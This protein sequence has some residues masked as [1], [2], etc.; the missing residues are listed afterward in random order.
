MPINTFDVWDQALLT[1]VILRPPLGRDPGA[2]EDTSPFLGETIAPNRQVAARVVKV[3]TAEI[4]PFGVGQLRAPD[5][6]PPLYKPAVSWSDTLIELAL[7]DEMERISEEDWIKLTSSDEDRRNSA[8]AS[9]VDRGRILKLRNDRLT[10]KYRWEMLLNGELTLTYPS[11][12]S[13]YV[14]YGFTSGHK[15][16]ASTLWSDTT[17]S[18]PVADI[19]AWSERLADDSGYYARNVFMNSKTYNYLIQSTPIKNAINFYAGGANSILRPR[20]GDILNLFETFAQD[21]NLVIYDNGYRA[22]GASGV[23]RTSLTKYLPDGKVLVTTD[24]TVDGTNIA[25]TMDGEVTVSTGY[26]STATRLGWQAE[27]MLDHMSKNHFLRSA[28]ARIPRL[29]LPDCVLVATV[30]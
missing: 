8:G 27:V 13:L 23:G 22:V 6:T 19:Q 28:S 11:G 30:A 2:A 15:V 10:E 24:L 18:N 14:N 1:D 3:R 16:T 17:N 9:L 29:L 7:L 20:R 21:V 25:D 5:A 4:Q 26:N 12:S